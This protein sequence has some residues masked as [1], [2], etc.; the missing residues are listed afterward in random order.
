MKFTVNGQPVEVAAPPTRRLLD[1]LR[2]DL[3]LTGTKPGCEIGRCGA[4]TVWLDGV[5]ANSCLVLALR[6]DGCAVTTV[7]HLDPDDEP[8]RALAEE[9]GLQCGYC[10]P[11]LLMTLRWLCAADPRPTAAEAEELLS[12]HLCRCTGYGGIKRSVARLFG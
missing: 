7:E 12:G 9:G 3:G 10:T 6:L 1:I 4:C 2:L 11:G 5:P 8:A